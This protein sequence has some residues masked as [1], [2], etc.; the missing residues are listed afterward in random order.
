MTTKRHRTT[1]DQPGRMECR[2]GWRFQ[3]VMKLE[4]PDALMSFDEEML[5]LERAF[6]RAY[7]APR[8]EFTVLAAPC[9]EREE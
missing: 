1:A 7:G 2:S 3:S 5:R 4:H 6:T 8:R 9:S